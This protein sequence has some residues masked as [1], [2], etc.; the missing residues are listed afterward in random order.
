MSRK[1]ERW[2]QS[3]EGGVERTRVMGEEGARR[4]E[5]ADVKRGVFGEGR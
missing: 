5:M 3:A 2:K 4:G 1:S